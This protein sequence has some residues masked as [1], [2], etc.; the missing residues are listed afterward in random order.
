[1]S[2]EQKNRIIRM[3]TIDE[4]TKELTELNVGRVNHQLGQV[5]SEIQKLEQKYN[6]LNQ[7]A[8]GD[9]SSVD[10]LAQ[11]AELGEVHQQTAAQVQQVRTQLELKKNELLAQLREQQIRID[12]WDKL[13]EKLDLEMK[14]S[15]AQRA[16][17]D[18][19]EAFLASQ[20]RTQS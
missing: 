19:D 14:A 13:L 5:R 10:T 9:A 3:R 6:Q 18:A 1:M 16:F 11:M 20:F 15:E 2:R 7:A 8:V 12:Q 4:R 17:A